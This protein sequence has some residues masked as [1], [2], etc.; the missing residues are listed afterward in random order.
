MALA[1]LV[2]ASCLSRSSTVTTLRR[3]F[4]W[5]SSLEGVS[6]PDGL[7]TISHAAFRG[8]IAMK[9]MTLPDSVTAICD[10]AFAGLPTSCEISLGDAVQSIG[11][12]AFENCQTLTFRGMSEKWQAISRADGW[13]TNENNTITVHC[14]NGD[15]TE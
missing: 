3:T 4:E 14:T 6:L 9:S 12:G 5:C 7:M 1:I 11:A 2:F 8:C 13:Y 10:N 15:V